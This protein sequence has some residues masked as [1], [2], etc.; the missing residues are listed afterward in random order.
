MFEEEAKKHKEEFIDVYLNVGGS[1]KAADMI[2]M[3]KEQSYQEGAEFGY[4]KA[5]ECHFVKDGEYPT[6][7][8]SKNCHVSQAEKVDKMKRMFWCVH[9]II[10]DS[11]GYYESIK[12]CSSKEKAEKIARSISKGKI[13]IRFEEKEI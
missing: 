6:H 2:G 9:H 11:E 3:Q 1:L 4:H 8:I 7:S 13:F 10:I 12:A 5:I